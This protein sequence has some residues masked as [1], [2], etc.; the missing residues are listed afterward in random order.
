M[1]FTSQLYTVY[2]GAFYIY[3]A[4]NEMLTFQ[5]MLMKLTSFW[6][7]NGCLVQQGYDLEVGAGTSNPA[8]FFRSLGPEPYNSVYIEP[9]RR[10]ADGRYGKNPNRFQHY[11]QCQVILKPSPPDIQDLCLQSLEAIGFNLSEHD[12]RFVHDDWENPTLGAW[13]LGW[14]V[15]MDGMEVTQFTYFQSVAGINLKPVTGEVTYGLERLAMYLQ[16]VDKFVDIQWNDKLTY[17][18]IYYRNEVE[19][20]QYNFEKST[21]EMWFRHF[22]D[23]EKEAKKLIAANLPI[24]AY[25]FVVKSSH[26]FNMLD[27]RGVISVTER[28]GYIARIRDLACQVAALY[29]TSREEQGYPLLKR[30]PAKSN[31]HKTSNTPLDT[32]LIHGDPN[33]REDFLLE[34]GSEEIPATF[35]SLGLQNLEKSMRQLLEKEGIPFTNMKTYGTPRRLAILVEKLALGKP[36][37][38]IEKKGPSVEQAFDAEGKLKPAGEGFFRSINKTPILLSAIRNKEV[39]GLEV[40][41]LNGVDY[42]FASIQL[43]GKATA[44]ILQENL[45]GLILN[46]DFPKKMR[47]GDQDITYPRPLRWITALF[48]KHVVPFTVGDIHSDRLSSGHRQLSPGSFALDKAQDYVSALKD[49]KV[50][51]DAGERQKSII[52]QLAELEKQ[53]DAKVISREQVM[54]QV[55]N[56]VEWPFITHAEFDKAYLKAPKE[57]LIS[58]MVEHQKYFPVMDT[59]GQLKNIFV[60]T[61]NTTPNEMI[62]KGNQM[63][64]SPRL[65]DGVFLYEQG[66]KMKLDDYNEKLKHI[67][68]QKELGSIYEKV[69]RI[70]KN[71]HI[72]QKHLKIS[73]PTKTERAALL[74]KADIATEMVFEFP[75]L[76]GIIGRYYALAQGEDAEVAQAIE[77]HWMPR[78]ENAPLPE[79]PTGILV[80]LADKIDNILGC[81]SANLK[82]TS[83]SDP[84]AL[85]R[86]SLGIAKILIKGKYRLPLN[87]VLSECFATFPKLSQNQRQEL[88]KEIG[89]FITNRI[90]TVFLDYGLAKDEIEAGLSYGFNDIYDAYCRVQALHKFRTENDKFPLLYEVYKRAKGQIND[91]APA[92]F[93]KA[94]LK[95]PA[96]ISLDR[97]LDSIQD[98]F[99]AAIS[100]HDY[101]QAYDLI[102]QIQPGLAAL[103]DKVKILADDPKLQENRIALL[104]RVFGLFSK[105]LDFSKI[106]VV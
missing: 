47:W 30:F 2:D 59:I 73:D 22:D 21:A 60:I 94:L 58:E 90:K 86:Q 54:P 52:A 95:E 84:Y 49:R 23:Y 32:D 50:M 18:D 89:A 85:R 5:D 8:T 13:G 57:V 92:N 46:M 81:Y 78:G 53:L 24:P 79:S 75:E 9:C 12:M 68:F 1:S 100:K 27:A 103:F 80:S 34:I 74:S 6:E 101:D 4:E 76:Q 70:I 62:R 20:S 16:K 102:A 36:S 35:V 48:G 83:S 28:T 91:H 39:Q 71:A 98:Q 51:V 26:A 11:F 63:A 93:S 37:Q 31:T 99:S 64:V 19:W 14:E 38:K 104:Q 25:D 45:P 44:N 77:E 55:V 96:E 105:L 3:I 41:S 106:Q 69:M 40:R 67:T 15:W 66:L 10:P 82:P 72:L 87:E 42:L 43:P 17:G 33:V 61:A 97:E 65:S 29:L 7:K 88:L 56:L